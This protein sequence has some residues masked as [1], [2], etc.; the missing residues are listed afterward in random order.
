[1]DEGLCYYYNDKWL[2]GHKC[3]SPRLF[4][5]SGLEL[6]PDE[7]SNEVYYDSTDVVD[8]VLEFDVVECKVPEISI[9]A[10]TGSSG[11]K[12]MRLMGVLQSQVVSILID[13]G[14]THS[15]LDPTFLAKVNLH[16]I[17]T[18]RMQV[19]IANGDTI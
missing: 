8:S 12:S 19:K 5:M 4:L 1:M 16:V 10:I 9:I 17:S 18:P 15:F 7:P 6:P 2:P 11:S 13:S 14:S 3:K